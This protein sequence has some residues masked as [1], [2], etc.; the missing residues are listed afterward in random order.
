MNHAKLSFRANSRATNHSIF[1]N[2][3]ST[4]L[5]VFGLECFIFQSIDDH[6]TLPRIQ[7]LWLLLLLISHFIESLTYPP[8]TFLVCHHASCM[9]RLLLNQ[10]KQFKIAMIAESAV[11]FSGKSRTYSLAVQQLVSKDW[12]KYSTANKTLFPSYRLQTSLMSNE[13]SEI[14]NTLCV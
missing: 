13:K 7:F 6:S 8:Y 1:S 3:S 12:N 5:D 9:A 4:L 14:I 2:K 11:K 10:R